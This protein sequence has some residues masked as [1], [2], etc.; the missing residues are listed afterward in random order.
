MVRILIVLTVLCFMAS[1]Q[2]VAQP[3][4]S[5]EELLR[6]AGIVVEG[7]V[8][9]S[10]LTRYTG[11]VTI[12][13]SKRYHGEVAD[14]IIIEWVWRARADN[15]YF[16]CVGD[17]FLFFLP[18]AVIH[19]TYSLYDDDDYDDIYYWKIER[20]LPSEFVAQDYKRYKRLIDGE[21][22]DKGYVAAIRG[23]FLI[24]ESDERKPDVF[25]HVTS[26]TIDNQ[27]ALSVDTFFV[28][29]YIGRTYEVFLMKMLSD[30]VYEHI[31]K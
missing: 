23:F 17:S 19:S 29:T 25:P 9:R 22:K 21:F 12:L 16:G 5:V 4:A 10:E 1:N 31:Y 13:V 7:T 27:S 11:K 15:R 8:V 20:F 18:G 24:E 26:L 2:S 14:T 3:L 28:D 30:Y 6:N